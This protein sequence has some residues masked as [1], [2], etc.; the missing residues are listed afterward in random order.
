MLMSHRL[1]Q[2]IEI[3]FWNTTIP[4][5][6]GIRWVRQTIHRGKTALFAAVPAQ[7]L[8]QSA[9]WS[10]IGLIFGVILGIL[11]AGL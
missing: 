6:L 7:V 9:V 1:F 8:L 2:N 11:S 4:A 3:A 10:I 5:L